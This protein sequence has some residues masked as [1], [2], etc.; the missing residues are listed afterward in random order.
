MTGALQIANR[1]AGL[2][3]EVVNTAEDED[4]DSTLLQD[5][6][7]WLTYL[8][9]KVHTVFSGGRISSFDPVIVKDALDTVEDSSETFGHYA[10]WAEARREQRRAEGEDVPEP[11]G[12]D[13]GFGWLDTIA[14]ALF[15]LPGSKK[16]DSTCDEK[17]EYE[18]N[19]HHGYDCSRWG[20]GCDRFCDAPYEEADEETIKEV[21]ES[22]DD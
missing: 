7:T 11:E 1:D 14:D 15:G 6:V 21:L 5:S 4:D 9:K 10:D 8:V 18:D 22:S 17:K 2:N 20:S 16:K 19:R 3:V 12:Y 13:T